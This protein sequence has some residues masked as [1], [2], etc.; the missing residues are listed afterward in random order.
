MK[1]D[2]IGLMTETVQP[3]E[4]FVRK[5][6]VWVTNPAEHPFR[7]EWLRYCDDSPVTGILREKPH[8]AYKV[9]DIDKE[10]EGLKVLIPP[11]ESVA[12]HVVGF[13]ETEDGAVV[14]LMQYDD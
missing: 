12:G 8:I 5:T 1:F 9:D 6:R 7:I 10:S 13:Y 3:N 14:E 11:F 2:H 4:R